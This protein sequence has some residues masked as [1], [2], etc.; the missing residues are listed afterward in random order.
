MDIP[1]E[2]A[3]AK[4]VD[5]VAEGVDAVVGVA[6]KLTGGILDM[7]VP[8]EDSMRTEIHEPWKEK[9]VDFA[10][11]KK[12]VQQLEKE[13]DP[14]KAAEITH[15]IAETMRNTLENTRIH[16]LAEMPGMRQHFEE[17]KKMPLTKDDEKS[18][19]AP[20]PAAAVA[21]QSSNKDES[22]M[23]AVP[24]PT[25]TTTEE[26]RSETTTAASAA[27]SEPSPASP[28]SSDNQKVAVWE[29]MFS[30]QGKGSSD[31]KLKK[32]EW[33]ALYQL[34]T[35]VLRLHRLVQLNQ[36]GCRL[37][38]KMCDNAVKKSSR[39][40]AAGN[41]P[42]DMPPRVEEMIVNCRLQALEDE[43]T[44]LEDEVLQFAQST[45]HTQTFNDVAHMEQE[46]VT[47][48]VVKWRFVIL[49]L[50]VFIVVHAVPMI[51]DNREAHNCAAMLAAVI[52]LWVSE[53]VPFFVSAMAIPLLSVP[54]GVLNSAS[55]S[56]EGA[57][58][59]SVT[60]DHVQILVLGGMC[61]GK[62]V[63]KH[64]L[65]NYIAKFL[66]R[67]T[68][69]NPDL[70]FLALLFMSALM[71]CCVSNVAAP[72]LVI[73]VIQ[74]I[75]WAMPNES[76]APQALVL[77]LALGCNFGG[78]MT[79]IASPQNAVAVKVLSPDV[80]SFV[81]WFVGSLP[82][83]VPGLI[84]SWAAVVY[85]WKPFKT[86]KRIPVPPDPVTKKK[87]AKA[88]AHDRREIF[89]TIITCAVTIILWLI[90]PEKTLGDSGVVAL[91]PIVVFF[92]TGILSK[93][94]FNALPW[95][96]LFLLAGGN[97]LGL[98][99]K[100]SGLLKVIIS[101]IE[102]WLDSHTGYQVTLAVIFIMLLV[103]TFVSHTVAALIMLP[104]VKS[105]S[106]CNPALP[107]SQVLLFM[108]IIM[109]SGA[110]AFP[111]SSF[112]NVNS[113]LAEDESG[114][115]YLVAKNFIGPGMACS[116]Y[117]FFVL[118]TVGLPWTRLILEGKFY[119]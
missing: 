107:S 116:L 104:F 17:I 98:C 73:S 53:A 9:Y 29:R 72:V 79:P 66:L 30:V 15:E 42:I 67:Y 119:Y 7:I 59:L 88:T 63:G 109:A 35:D 86:I 41:S 21:A 92:G 39:A 49:A 65:E 11:L 54:F 74:R 69:H 24:I 20:A 51:P 8:F 80:V 16:F 48:W 106:E 95:H 2:Q 103:T 46:Q 26:K 14:A 27:T 57:K 108:S 100:E 44:A 32:K 115:P 3:V 91:I 61:M 117:S 89:V 90:P 83:A 25:A 34:N 31:S 87:S 99:V 105:V 10:A 52:V 111:I 58:I 110:M 40:I 4:T 45:F 18:A 102:P 68:A 70:F 101:A 33:R 1:I 93:N 85:V 112:P 71:C 77:G 50:V 76:G 56:E 60:W 19:S 6:F 64:K 28:V 38:A 13:Q 12:L 62:A 75:L 55:K 113:L 96:L 47:K 5:T 78:M 114:K 43:A 94:D 82:I 81:S 36:E 22:E 118:V 37:I 23:K 97:M 84:I